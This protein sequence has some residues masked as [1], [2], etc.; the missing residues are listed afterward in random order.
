MSGLLMKTVG[1]IDENVLSLYTV[2]LAL[3]AV[4]AIGM[5]GTF[6][7][8]N[9][10]S[11]RAVIPFDNVNCLFELCWKHSMFNIWLT[12]VLTESLI[13]ILSLVSYGSNADAAVRMFTVFM[14]L[15]MVNLVIHSVLYYKVGKNFGK[16][17]PFRIGLIVLTPFFMS[18]LGWGESRYLLPPHGKEECYI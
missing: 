17:V 9:I 2:L 8:M 7:K 16:S 13:F 3:C 18:I 10:S 12:V 5:W 4:S 6:R 14:A 11:V 1:F 15:A